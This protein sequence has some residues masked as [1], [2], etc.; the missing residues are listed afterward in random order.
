MPS[1]AFI[2]GAHFFGLARST[3]AS[4]GGIF[5]WVGV[6]MCIL[7]AAI[8]YAVARSLVSSSQSMAITGFGCAFILWVSALCPLA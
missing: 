8:I 1:I 6:F 2:V 4:G 5:V 3:A 7:A